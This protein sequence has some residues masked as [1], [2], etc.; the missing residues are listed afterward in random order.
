ML[1]YCPVSAIINDSLPKRTM[2]VVN[3]T[4]LVIC[5]SARWMM[6]FKVTRYI[7]KTFSQVTVVV[8]DDG[9]SGNP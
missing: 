7:Y 3:L 5:E 9:L 4:P 2:N 8:N 1:E 6:V